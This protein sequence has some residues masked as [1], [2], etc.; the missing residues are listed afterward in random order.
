VDQ[1]EG[2]RAETSGRAQSLKYMERTAIYVTDIVDMDGIGLWKEKP[3]LFVTATKAEEKL[4]I[5]LGN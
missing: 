3:D 4:K 2:R 1:D 5:G